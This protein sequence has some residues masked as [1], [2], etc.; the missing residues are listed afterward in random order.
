[1]VRDVHDSSLRRP[2]EESAEILKARPASDRPPAD[3]IAYLQPIISVREREVRLVEA[4]ARGVAADGR[5][6]PPAELWAEATRRGTEV[7]LGVQARQAAF[8]AYRQIAHHGRTPLLSLNTDSSLVLDGAR[9]AER[10]QP[11]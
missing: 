2:G 5:I 11:T 3:V 1:M 7:A 4:L 9:G 8:R 10:W 6:K